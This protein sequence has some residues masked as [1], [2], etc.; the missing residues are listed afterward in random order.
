M[1]SQDFPKKSAKSALRQCVASGMDACPVRPEDFAYGMQFQPS[2]VPL[3]FEDAE[4]VTRCLMDREAREENARHGFN[5]GLSLTLGS[6]LPAEVREERRGEDVM[7]SSYSGNEYAVREGSVSHPSSHTYRGAGSVVSVLQNSP[8]LKPAQQ[9][10]DEVVCV[11]NAVEL[12]LDNRVRESIVRTG[13][14]YLGGRAIGQEG[15]RCLSEEKQEVQIRITKLTSLLNE[16]ESRCQNYFH[17]MDRVVSSFEMVAGRG[18]AAAYTALTIQA[19]SK[20]FCNLRD[21]IVTQLN[22]SRNS[23]LEDVPRNQGDTPHHKLINRKKRGMLHH[24]GTIQIRQVWRPLRGLPEDSVALLRAWLFEHFLHPYPND[25]EKLMLA[26][27][28][29][30]SRNQIS[31]WFIN[32]RVRLWKPMIEEMYREEFAEDMQES[33]P[34]S[35]L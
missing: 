9:L 7:C 23:L 4:M 22:A 35:E 20:H 12:G 5:H 27:Q 34:S 11:S 31:N 16:L 28:T 25:N 29:G 3:C 24:L 2:S 18:A 15:D 1:V 6:R 13:G 8:Y 19:M 33:E 30:L 32:A 14:S 21:T 17:Q 26:S 10:L